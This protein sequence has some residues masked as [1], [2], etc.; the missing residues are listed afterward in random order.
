M[1]NLILEVSMIDEYADGP[2]VAVVEIDNDL[3]ERILKL[4][5][6]V[7]ASSV[8]SMTD[9]DDSPEFFKRDFTVVAPLT[10][11]PLTSGL[12][13]VDAIMLNVTDSCFYWSGCLKYCG[14]PFETESVGLSLLRREDQEGTSPDFSDDIAVA[15]DDRIEEVD[16][17]LDAVWREINA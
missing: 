11:L 7:K 1:E 15:T 8:Y 10:P 6:V 12:F 5:S 3:K 14:T 13:R 16:I 17:N 9:F 4:S 2:E